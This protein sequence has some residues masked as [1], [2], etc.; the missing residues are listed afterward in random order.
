MPAITCPARG[1]NETFRDDLDPTVLSQLISIHAASFHPKQAETPGAKIEKVRRPTL[2][3][4]GSTEDW[5]FFLVRWREY[6]LATN[7]QGQ[8]MI[9][10]LIECA[11][12]D[13]QKA[14]Y[15]VYGSLA[16]Y[17]EENAL[18]EIRKLAVKL[19]NVLV[20]RVDLHNLTQ[21][22][23]EAVRAFAARLRG[24][25]KVC[26]FTK[27]K[28]CTCGED[29]QVDYADDIIRDTLIRGLA[30]VDIQLDILG[31][32]NQKL[33]LEETIALA[34][35]KESGK[36]SASILTT[37]PAVSA[38]ATSAVSANATSAYRK[39]TNQNHVSKANMNFNDNQP[40]KC[41]HCGQKFHGWRKHERK[42]HCPAYDHQCTK[43]GILHHLE[44]VCR[45][46][47][48]K[49]NQSKPTTNDAV[50]HE[51]TA[52][53]PSQETAAEYSNFFDS[54]SGLFDDSTSASKSL[55]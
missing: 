50:F 33:T 7:I 8:Q 32:C 14:I 16:D 35:S 51:Y 19:E 37:H 23:D 36:R 9:S 39:N 31:Q 21:D 34:E 48:Q 53:A 42:K 5:E 28:K 17:T 20:A 25:S 26:E 3:Q 46:R 30:D 13:L 4:G 15:R 10:Q 43:C 18:K 1:C 38:N 47:Q 27:S 54:N 29:V 41:N 52:E 49:F 12:N 55:I 6:K 11:D 2:S 22:R 45:S 40:K 24:K 44:S